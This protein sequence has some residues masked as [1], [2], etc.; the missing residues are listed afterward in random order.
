MVGRKKVILWVKIVKIWI[1][2]NYLTFPVNKTPKIEY[3]IKINKM[4]HSLHLNKLN[5]SNEDK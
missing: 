5:I 4:S 1:F 2:C 3:Q